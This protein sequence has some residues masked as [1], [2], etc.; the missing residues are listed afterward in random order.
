MCFGGLY[1]PKNRG[2]SNFEADGGIPPIAEWSFL[3]GSALWASPEAKPFFQLVATL[4]RWS[5]LAVLA[6]PPPPSATRSDLKS[7]KGIQ[8]CLKRVYVHGSVLRA[9]PGG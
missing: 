7:K 6:L 8:L 4:L 5:K 9:S 3:L 1:T 2:R